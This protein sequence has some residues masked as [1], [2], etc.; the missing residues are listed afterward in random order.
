MSYKVNNRISED[1]EG[2][3]EDDS[4]NNKLNKNKNT[5]IKI[6]LSES[7]KNKS[8]YNEEENESDEGSNNNNSLSSDRFSNELSYVN[9]KKKIKDKYIAQIEQLKNELK[10]EKQINNKLDDKEYFDE[11]KKLK[12]ELNLKSK[13]LKILILSNKKQKQALNILTKEI[14]EINYRKENKE[15]DEEIYREGTS[16]IF[17]IEDKEIYNALNKMNLLKKE[18]EYIKNKLYENN[19]YNY[20]INLEDNTKSIKDLI[21][22]LIIE[23]KILNKQLEQHKICI[24][25]KNEYYN[26]YKNLKEELYELKKKIK[27]FDIMI[28]EL[29]KK[30][31]KNTKNFVIKKNYNNNMRLNINL[32]NNKFSSNSTPNLKINRNINLNKKNK[33]IELPLIYS[34]SVKFQNKSSISINFNKKIKEYLDGD[35]DQYMTLMNK[36]NSIENNKIINENNNSKEIN[37]FNS[38]ILSLDEKYKYLKMNNKESNNNIRLLKYRLN[39]ITNENKKQ[40]KKLN[41]LKKDLRKEIKISNN[42]NKEISSLLTEINLIKD[43]VKNDNVKN[44][45]NDIAKYIKKLKLEKRIKF[46]KNNIND[47][48]IQVNFS[49]DNDDDN[50]NDKDYDDNYYDE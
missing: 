40:Y 23:K 10:L 3:E 41:E 49:D 36:I 42:K 16:S 37:T 6:D 45:R 14:E 4:E 7:D 39:I 44:I 2:E 50:D 12:K 8:S 34:N 46:K 33:N 11:V 48:N 30:N 22:K 25:E 28:E 29:I 32:I 1:K 17:K 24:K 26:E 5:K 31:N 19:D 38:K 27:H 15:N 35:E 13:N 43:T 47:E 9:K 18:N 21:D 20:Q